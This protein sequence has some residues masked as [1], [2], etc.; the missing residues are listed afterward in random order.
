ME[1]ENKNGQ[2]DLCMKE[3][4]RMAKEMDK[5]NSVSLTEP[6]KMESGQMIIFNQVKLSLHLKKMISM[7]AD[8]SM[9]ILREKVLQKK[10]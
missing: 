9:D 3:I 10:M 2:M 6:I 8:G 1:R 7:K 4:G 5:E